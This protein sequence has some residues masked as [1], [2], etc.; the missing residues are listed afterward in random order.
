ME[1]QAAEGNFVKRILTLL[2]LVATCGKA[3]A[4]EP[5][6]VKP[7]FPPGFVR[8]K[9][10][11]TRAISVRTHKFDG[12]SLCLIFDVEL[13]GS[14]SNV[15]ILRSSNNQEVDDAVVAWLAS[16]RHDPA[17]QDGTPVVPGSFS[18]NISV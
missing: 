16:Q 10:L 11:N 6:L 8:P 12:L 17:T 13:D 3:L 7:P 14:H 15:R 9:L 4:D 1:R 2:A 5:I 18:A